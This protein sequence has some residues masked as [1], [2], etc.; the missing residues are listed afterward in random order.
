MEGG[1]IDA[2]LIVLGGGPAGAAAAI[3]AAMR[4]LRVVLCERL[5]AGR[6]RPGETLHPGIAPLLGQLGLGDAL[7]AVTGAR[8]RGIWIAWGGPRR[9]E[10]FGEDADGP[11]QGFQVW[12]A[13]FDT[14]L[15]DRARALGVRLCQPCAVTGVLGDAARVEGVM[16]SA[17]A[18]RAPVTLDATGAARLLGRALG[19][20]SP[21]RSP[22]LHARYGYAAGSCAARDDAPALTGDAAGWTW[23]ARVRPGLYQWTRLAFAGQTAA[24]WRPAEFAALSPVGRSRGADVTWRLAAPSAGPGWFLIGDAA[25]MLDPT[26]SHGVQ[27]AIMSGIMAAHLAVPVLDGRAP[28]GEAAAAYHDWLSGWFAADCARLGQFYADLGAP[29]FARAG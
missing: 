18:L 8:H 3:A 9:F 2:D 12:R 24:D 14:M 19:V 15:L 7:A 5:P 23:T 10:P 29:G 4:G 6:D 1:H 27:R 21:A 17:G 16:T 11:W 22:R 20:A 26:S 28:A 25:A 13:D